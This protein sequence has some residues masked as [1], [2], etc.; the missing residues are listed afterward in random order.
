MK[1]G[2]LVKHRSSGDCVGIVIQC[3]PGTALY[4]KVYWY[5]HTCYGSSPARDLKVISES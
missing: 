4:T 5:T 1:P 2:D 3:Y